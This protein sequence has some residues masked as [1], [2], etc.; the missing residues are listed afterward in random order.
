[1]VRLI[2]ITQDQIQH[3]LHSTNKKTQ[4]GKTINCFLRFEIS[5]DRYEATTTN[6][7]K[8]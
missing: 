4:N 7:N 8:I 1:M 2:D 3:S 6:E 5:S